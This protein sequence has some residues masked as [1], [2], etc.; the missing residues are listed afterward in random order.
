[1]LSIHYKSCVESW[2]TTIKKKKKKK[3]ERNTKIYFIN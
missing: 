3:N 2:K 1:M